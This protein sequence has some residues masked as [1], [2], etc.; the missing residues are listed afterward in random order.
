MTQD[1]L[2]FAHLSVSSI[3]TFLSCPRKFRLKYVDRERGSHRSAALAVGTAWHTTIGRLLFNHAQGDESD[4][5]ELKEHLRHALSSELRADGPPVLFEDGEDEG[6]LV[7]TC[8]KMLEVFV[9]R[10]KLPSKV[11]AIELP[12]SVELHDP[13]TGEVLSVPLIGSIDAVV[14]DEGV[15][16]WELKSGKR[17]WSQDQLDFDLQ[18]TAYRIGVRKQLPD[19]VRLKLLVTTKT[20]APDVQVERLLRSKRDEKDLMATASSLVRAV[21]AGVD[22]PARSWACRSCEVAGVCR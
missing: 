18:A 5:Q 15:E 17:K 21:R 13:E 2:P 10:V 9:K 1:D 22:H 12:F 19:R 7:D 6:Q 8:Q 16:L 20:K 11:H 14:E 3:K 4:T